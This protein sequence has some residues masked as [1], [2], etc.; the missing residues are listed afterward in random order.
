MRRCRGGF[1]TQGDYRDH[2]FWT[3]FSERGTTCRVALSVGHRLVLDTGGDPSSL[4]DVPVR[5]PPWLCKLRLRHGHDVPY[6]VV[7]CGATHHRL[8]VFYGIS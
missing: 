8:V 4:I 5:Y 7:T 3:R 6:G 1:D 2:D